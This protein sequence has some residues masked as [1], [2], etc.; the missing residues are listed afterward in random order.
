MIYYFYHNHNLPFNKCSDSIKVFHSFISPSI[1]FSTITAVSLNK[2]SYFLL[3]T[4]FIMSTSL[5]TIEHTLH[6]IHID[7]FENQT[8][9][10]FSSLTNP[11]SIFIHR[12]YSK[13]SS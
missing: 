7:Q 5:I 13:S 9:I 2:K 10:I 12:S 1:S 3:Q 6:I 8:I 11:S 4:F